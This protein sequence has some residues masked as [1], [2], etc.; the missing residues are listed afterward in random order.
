MSIE[1][2]ATKKSIE[3]LLTKGA[4]YKMD[5]TPQYGIN[6]IQWRDIDEELKKNINLNNCKFINTMD[7]FILDGI[8]FCPIK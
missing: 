2:K 7:S 6:L 3:E 4:E 5:E 1:F 8:E